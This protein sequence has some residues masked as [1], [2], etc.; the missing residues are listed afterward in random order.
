MAQP[1]QRVDPL[2][3]QNFLLEIDG[4]ARASFAEVT[5]GDSTIDVTEYREGG[6][7][8][9]PRKLPGLTKH[10]NIVLKWGLTSDVELWNW[11]KDAV[12]GTVRRRNGSIVGLDRTGQEAARWN[13]VN[14]FP[15][16]YDTPDFNAE[17]N[18]VALETLELVHEGIERVS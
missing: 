10:G 6:E 17:G 3:N 7:N 14:A 15:S 5:G 16:K 11:H 4:L 18:D 2:G 12:R 1:G 13:F 8:T 9:T